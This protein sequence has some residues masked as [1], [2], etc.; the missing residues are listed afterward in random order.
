MHQQREDKRIQI[1]ERRKER[2]R[3]RN[4]EAEREE[5]KEQRRYK[6]GDKEKREEK[7]SKQTKALGVAVLPSSEWNFQSREC[8]SEA[9][10][11]CTHTQNHQFQADAAALKRF[12]TGQ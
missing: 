8:N 10:T 11:A 1:K 3:Q 6:R 9:A 4:K 2:E 5:C 12:A 7:N